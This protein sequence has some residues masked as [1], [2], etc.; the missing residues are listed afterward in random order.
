[1]D[2]KTPAEQEAF[3]RKMQV[4]FSVAQNKVREHSEQ[5]L[6]LFLSWFR[7]HGSPSFKEWVALSTWN[8]VPISSL[9]VAFKY[10]SSMLVERSSIYDVSESVFSRSTASYTKDHVANLSVVWPTLMPLLT[11]LGKSEY[12]AE[13]TFK[14][15]DNYAM[16]ILT[17]KGPVDFKSGDFYTEKWFT[18]VGASHDV[19]VIDEKTG[20]CPLF[21]EEYRDFSAEY[22]PFLRGS[23]TRY[24][25]AI[26]V[27][28]VDQIRIVGARGSIC[29]ICDGVSGA[30]GSDKAYEIA[31]KTLLKPQMCMAE[32]Q[33]EAIRSDKAAYG[34]KVAELA[35]KGSQPCVS[36]TT[37][38]QYLLSKGIDQ[39][40][41]NEL[42]VKISES[43]ISLEQLKTDKGVKALAITGILQTIDVLQLS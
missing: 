15:R 5:K 24:S 3:K 13:V 28:C 43:G 31:F 1:M 30:Y 18:A 42:T 6:T 25:K 2:S 22:N 29:I 27:N 38:Q 35:A 9:P 23:L 26:P 20:A 14:A 34:A 41:A 33:L 19:L 10:N 11:A 32:K 4:E 40:K 12:G 36:S 17:D 37:I 21:P 16:K 39:T 8:H 7:S